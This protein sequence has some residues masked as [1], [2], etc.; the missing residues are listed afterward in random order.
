MRQ[1]RDAATASKLFFFLVAMD[2]KRW[3][4]YAQR[5]IALQGIHGVKARLPAE[6]GQVLEVPPDEKFDAGD[7]ANGDVPRIVLEGDEL[8]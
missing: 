6:V 3:S 1:R 7:G 2:E 8:T 4:N 5:R